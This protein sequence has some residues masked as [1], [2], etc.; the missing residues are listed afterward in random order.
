VSTHFR[1]AA[2]TMVHLGAELITSDEIALYELVKNSFDAGSPR[3]KIEVSAPFP[4]LKVRR[5]AEQVREGLVSLDTAL[6]RF[7]SHAAEAIPELLKGWVELLSTI[8]NRNKFAD[9]LIKLADNECVIAVADSGHGMSQEE[10]TQVFLVVGTPM[11]FS[12]KRKATQRD[13][14]PILG[15][16][17]IG[18]LSMMRLGRYASVISARTG[19][20]AWAQVEFDWQEFD[21]PDAMI[22][23]VPISVSR[24]DSR[25]ASDL[26]GT[27]IR[28]WG[29]KAE[30]D[31]SKAKQFAED[32]LIRLRN[33]FRQ[34]DFRFPIDVT[35]N[36]SNRIPVPLIPKP[37]L[38]AAHVH[39]TARFTPPDEP[40]EEGTDEKRWKRSVAVKLALEGATIGFQEYPATTEEVCTKLQVGPEL[41]KSLGEFQVDFYW[42]NRA[43]LAAVDGLGNTKD[44]KRQLDRWAGGFAIYRDGFRVGMTGSFEDD[45]LQLDSSALRRQGYTVNRLQVI[46]A[47]SLDA[48]HNPRLI[49]RSNREG[50]IECP[51]KDLLR[52]LILEFVVA[53]LRTSVQVEASADRE[54]VLQEVGQERLE[55]TEKAFKET[56]RLIRDV[57]KQ[58]PSDL[59]P[60]LDEVEGHLEAFQDRIRRL[61]TGLRGMQETR[62]DILEMAGVGLVVESMLHELAR[63][64][65]TARESM[66]TFRLVGRDSEVKAA[67]DTLEAQM[68]AINARIRAIDPL[69]PSGRHR[70]EEFDLVLM[71]Q[72]ILNGF[73]VR[74]ERHGIEARL[75]VRGKVPRMPVTVNLVRGLIA[76]VFE[77][78]IGNAVYWLRESKTVLLGQRIIEIDIDDKASVVTVSDNGPGIAP[79]NKE[80]IFEPHFSLKPKGKGLGLYIAREIARYHNAELYLDAAPDDHG[81][82]HDFIL[83]LPRE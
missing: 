69:S 15:D 32:F 62:E 79:A 2:R 46:G 48:Q 63:I 29:L 13:S 10:L 64:T 57:T 41:L 23:D 51:E 16:K 17:G 52:R 55:E 9:A 50:L 7:K 75:T 27:T 54:T 30:W 35:V 28:I 37:L 21:D 59:K 34:R 76:H 53:P 11:K 44:V 47:V 25:G 5:L 1:V 72:A 66:A 78:L 12:Q 43:K 36:G 49:D 81:Q 18:R 58:V 45:W 20:R 22:D 70:K 73:R 56:R 68:K 6:S 38:E 4:H 67:F 33:P 80:H 39:G 42:Y 31:E 19:A 61:H 77:N 3:V 8:T 60:K 71:L 82:L 24:G 14:R 40:Y 26:S 74:F 65:A 83:E